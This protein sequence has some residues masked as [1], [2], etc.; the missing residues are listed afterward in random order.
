MIPYLKPNPTL[1]S[2]L[3]TAEYS[4]PHRCNPAFLRRHLYIAVDWY[5]SHYFAYVRLLLDVLMID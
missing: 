3:R 5:V 1:P 2:R 4:F